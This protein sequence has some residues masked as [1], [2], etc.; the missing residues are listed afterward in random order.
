MRGAGGGGGEGGVC[1]AGKEV[2]K[3]RGGNKAAEKLVNQGHNDPIVCSKIQKE[4][5]GV[6]YESLVF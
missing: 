1:T 5:G 6:M 4:S 2:K 3:G